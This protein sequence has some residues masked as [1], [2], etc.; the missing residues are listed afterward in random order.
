MKSGEVELI[1]SELLSVLCLSA[2]FVSFAYFEVP[3]LLYVIE[4]GID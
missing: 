3:C 2:S 4:A 1:T